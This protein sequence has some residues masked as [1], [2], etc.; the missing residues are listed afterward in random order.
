MVAAFFG[1]GADGL[2]RQRVPEN[3][4]QAPR[5][6]NYGRTEKMCEGVGDI[7][8]QMIQDALDSWYGR[9]VDVSKTKGKPLPRKY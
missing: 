9:V 3:S 1:F 8:I 5:I 4:A 2:F 6:P 7:P